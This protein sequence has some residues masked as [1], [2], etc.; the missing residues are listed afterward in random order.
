MVGAFGDM[1]AWVPGDIGWP[2]VLPVVVSP[3]IVVEPVVPSLGIVVEPVVGLVVEPL[4]P[5]GVVVPIVPVV[6]AMAAPLASSAAAKM[7]VFIVL[8]SV[9]VRGA[10][11]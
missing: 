6:W 10:C 7:I 9:R 8:V 3:G 1:G 5:G 4:P 2:I 11:A